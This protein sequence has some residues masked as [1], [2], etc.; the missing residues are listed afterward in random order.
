MRSLSRISRHRSPRCPR[1][2]QGVE[3]TR[4]PLPTLPLYG[5]EQPQVFGLDESVRRRQRAPKS[6]PRPAVIWMT[7]RPPAGRTVRNFCWTHS[8]ANREG[9]CPLRCLLGLV[10]S[11]ASAK[12]VPMHRNSPDWRK[13]NTNHKRVS[14][15]SL[16]AVLRVSP[17]LASA[18][19]NCTQTTETTVWKR[20]GV[21][22]PLAL[23]QA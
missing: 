16:H 12:N 5:Y 15:L 13:S 14:V 10:S 23:I 6:P 18:F 20:T 1:R 21:I 4:F 22:S 9:R 3:K 2:A 11:L 17:L 7:G 19:T 8:P